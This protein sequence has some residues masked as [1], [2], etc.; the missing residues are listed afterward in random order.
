MP[1]GR[2]SLEDIS[3]AINVGGEEAADAIEMST[4]TGEYVIHVDSPT[5]IGVAFGNIKPE[6][7]RTLNKIWCDAQ[8]DRRVI[9]GY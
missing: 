3:V 6:Y 4:K 2:G 7:S 8:K 1:G 5:S 9:W